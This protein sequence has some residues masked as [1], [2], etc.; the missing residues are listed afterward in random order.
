MRGGDISNESP[1]RI[2]VTLE[3]VLTEKISEH[4]VLGIFKTEKV[5]YEYNI[6]GLNKLWNFSGRLGVAL[7]LVGIGRSEKE[8]EEILE[9]LNNTGSNPFSRTYAYDTIDALVAQL[10]YRP[11]LAG[12]IDA[13]ANALRYGSWYIDMNRAF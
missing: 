7:D 2:F 4:K 13:P 12:V 10:P 1:K 6:L 5:E 3:C 11:D 9:D 8:M